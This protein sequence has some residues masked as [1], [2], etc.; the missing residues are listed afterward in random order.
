MPMPQSMLPSAPET[1]TAS[2]AGSR[3]LYLRLPSEEDPRWRR[4]QLILSMFPG[5]ESVVCYFADTKLR[6]GT[7]AVLQESMLEELR[8]ILG[9][10][11]V[12]VK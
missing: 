5:T 4:T 7:R 2:S 1:Q 10:E 11:S 3:R 6:R 8:R 9:K 12:V